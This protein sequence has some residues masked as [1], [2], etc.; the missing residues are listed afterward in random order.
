M[1]RSQIPA[2]LTIGTLA[3]AAGVGVETV[4]F[5]QRKGLL[6][7]PTRESGVRRYGSAHVRRLRFIRKAQFAG[8]TLREIGELLDLDGGSDRP[9]VRDLARRRIEALDAEITE[10]SAARDALTRL[11]DEC[12]ASKGRTCPI[13][14]SFG[15]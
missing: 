6:D 2:S 3:A 13:L 10:L 15:I 8:F 12:G 7:Q 4:R 1:V 5:Y 14:D 9:R 11:A